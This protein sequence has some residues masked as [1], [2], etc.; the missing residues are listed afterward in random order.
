MIPLHSTFNAYRKDGE[1]LFTATE[2][3]RDFRGPRIEGRGGSGLEL[4]LHW[5]YTTLKVLDLTNE[6]L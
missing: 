5:S 3:Y 4:I 1:I 2:L 6:G